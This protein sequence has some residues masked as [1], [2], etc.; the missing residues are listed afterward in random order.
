MP[1]RTDAVEVKCHDKIERHL[2]HTTKKT[3]REAFV[4][5]TFSQ[6]HEP[7]ARPLQVDE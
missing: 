7:R 3:V 1:Q 2:H 4:E 5:K 6:Y